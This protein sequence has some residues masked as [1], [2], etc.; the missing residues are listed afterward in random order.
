MMKLLVK[1]KELIIFSFLFISVI[2]CFSYCV[3][4]AYAHTP[5][6]VI[7]ALELSPTFS[8]DKTLF[9]AISDHLFKS[10]DGGFSWTELVN[11]LDHKH[12]L[13]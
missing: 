2:A 10:T 5:H 9:I 4:V 8:K 12:L 3:E 6:D 1:C 13:L 7:D 11:G